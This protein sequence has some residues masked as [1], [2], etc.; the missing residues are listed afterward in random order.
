MIFNNNK[1]FKFYTLL[2]KLALQTDH[3][4]YLLLLF[5]MPTPSNLLDPC[6]ILSSHS[7]TQFVGKN[8]NK[9]RVKSESVIFLINLNTV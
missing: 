3:Y 1:I 5:Y 8:N 2:P 4:Q 7:V 9:F 6:I